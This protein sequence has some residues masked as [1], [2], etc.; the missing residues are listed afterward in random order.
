[1]LEIVIHIIGF[2]IHYLSDWLNIVDIVVIIISI[3]FVML[4]LEL[5]DDNSFRGFLKIR[6]IFRLLRIF[7]LIRKLNAVRVRREMRM[8]KNVG[9]IFGIQTPVERVLEILNSMRDMI[10][11]SE[12][13]LIQDIN[14]CI[15][16][17][18]TNKLYD[19]DIIDELEEEDG[20][21]SPGKKSSKKDFLGWI[22]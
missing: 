22:H 8:K 19:V 5:P 17:I 2:H 14:Y 15:E 4:D 16:M 21:K 13:K 1:M 18:S 9:L 3:I 6:G 20:K 10:E 12:R 7:I 11:P